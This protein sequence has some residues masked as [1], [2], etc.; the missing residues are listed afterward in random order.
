MNVMEKMNFCPCCGRH[1]DLSM[2][3]C[4]RGTEYKRIGEATAEP[5]HG[6][7]RQE[8][9]ERLNRYQSADIQDKLIINLRDLNHIMRSLYEGKGSQKRILILLKEAGTMTQK[10]LTER[11]GI[12]P[13]SASEVVAKLE[14]SGYIMRVP[15]E[16]DRR[17]MNIILTEQ[18][19]ALAET[20]AMQRKKRHE[21]MFFCLSEEEK[22][23][24]LNLL[25][26]INKDWKT[27]YRETEREPEHY[28]HHR[29]HRHHGR[30]EK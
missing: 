25:E 13:G 9:S 5:H 2:P 30:E 16:L 27:R 20:A 26:K 1:C 19:R 6:K 8:N 24:F 14:D 4:E 28:G 11:L 22:T 23:T 29:W 3:Q 21:E 15:S 12:Q 18:G 17:T 10:E 7:R